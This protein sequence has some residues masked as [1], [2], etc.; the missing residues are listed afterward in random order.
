M[1]GRNGNNQLQTKEELCNLENNTNFGTTL[2]NYNLK[3][4]IQIELVG[5][6]SMQKTIILEAA[7]SVW[8]C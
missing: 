1:Y 6:I 4:I 3:A 5:G 7:N 8:I 2:F